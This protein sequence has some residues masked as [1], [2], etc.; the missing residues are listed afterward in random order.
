MLRYI[1]YGHR[2]GKRPPNETSSKSDAVDY[3]KHNQISDQHKR[4]QSVLG[5]NASKCNR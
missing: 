4:S 2:E 5:P 3:L 1:L